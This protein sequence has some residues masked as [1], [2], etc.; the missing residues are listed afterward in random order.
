MTGCTTAQLVADDGTQY[1]PEGNAQ[2]QG[3]FGNAVAHF[4]L[5]LLFVGLPKT[6]CQLA[7]YTLR[8]T[9]HGR[10]RDPLPFCMVLFS[11]GLVIPP[12]SFRQEKEKGPAT[13]LTL[14]T[15]N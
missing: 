14:Q 7:S 11:N 9:R 8:G 3:Q 12:S 1:D 15:G 10:R 4:F 6:R 5:L 2:P 13:G